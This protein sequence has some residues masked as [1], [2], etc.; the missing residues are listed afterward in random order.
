[1]GIQGGNDIFTNNNRD[2]T[3]TPQ[4]DHIL[5][6][7]LAEIAL[8]RALADTGAMTT[9]MATTQTTDVLRHAING[10]TNLNITQARVNQAK[11]GPFTAA[12]NRIRSD[13]LRTV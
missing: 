13:R 1:M 3:P 7:Q 12:M 4:V 2:N 9:S 8:V 11:R 6:V 5:E 10:H